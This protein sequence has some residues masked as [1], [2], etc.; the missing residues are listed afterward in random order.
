M[1][2]NNFSVLL[3]VF[4]FEYN[5]IPF[6]PRRMR[7]E[8]QG[9]ILTWVLLIFCDTIST[10]KRESRNIM[11]KTKYGVTD[12]SYF[13]YF[14]GAKCVSLITVDIQLN[15]LDIP[16][17]TTQYIQEQLHTPMRIQKLE[18]KSC[19]TNSIE[20]S[21]GDALLMI[22]HYEF[23]ITTLTA[24]IEACIQ[25]WNPRAQFMFM[26]L[27]TGNLEKADILTIFEKIWHQYNILH[28]VILPIKINPNGIIINVSDIKADI[29]TYDPFTSH[30]YNEAI[31]NSR[32]WNLKNLNGMP[33]KISLFGH[34]PTLYL[35][36][37]SNLKTEVSF[38][39]NDSQQL[40]WKSYHGVDGQM[41]STMA[42]FMNFTPKIMNPSNADSYGF[43]L[44]NGTFTGALGDVI[45]KQVDISFNS[46]FIKHYNT[47]D[48]EFSNPL[49]SDKMCIIVPKAKPIPRWRRILLSFNSELWLILLCTFSIVTTFKFI[50]RMCHNSRKLEWVVIFETFQVFLLTG[51]HKPPK[52]TSERCVYASCLIFCLVVMNAFQGLLVTNITYPIYEP[53]IH[54][55][56][57]LDHS[58]LP[59]W[60]RSPEN[61]DVFK[62]IGTPVTERLLQKFDVFN[63]SANELL[64]HVANLTDAAAFIR[65]TSSTYTESRYVAQDG[66]QLIHTVEECPAYYHL[67]YIVPRGSP[68]LPLINN[69]ILR[70]NEAGLTFKWHSDGMDVNS[71]LSYR[72]QNYGRQEALRVFSLTDLQLAFYISVSGLI[73][74]IL[75]FVLEAIT[76][77]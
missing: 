42:H 26:I 1:I 18:T 21:S 60:S 14:V 13:N 36:Q 15:S 27:Y 50:L 4:V 24:Q 54:T 8:T 20:I 74:S 12:N 58:N 67:A 63:G 71:L 72:K 22:M 66:S 76:G 62:D 55:L 30:L 7:L 51:I 9:N 48:I 73:L 52:I 40:N 57:E 47:A 75:V 2:L 49:F 25:H 61:K 23:F 10:T 29:W 19:K 45:Y 33:L 59:I 69:F 53:D 65:E 77:H 37:E 28:V 3:I 34:Y 56:A 43:P 32:R 64:N 38:C 17:H 46:R 16:T 41:F 35:L 70:M 44:P 11:Y 39:S 5:I 6:I 31:S 68:Y